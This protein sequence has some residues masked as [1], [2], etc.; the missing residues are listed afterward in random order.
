MLLWSPR[1]LAIGIF[2]PQVEAEAH[3]ALSLHMT[4]RNQS[5]RNWLA[6]LIRGSR[7]A[8]VRH[9]VSSHDDVR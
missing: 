4:M 1:H 5:A 8:V 9:G 6:V 3:E 2:Y 7:C